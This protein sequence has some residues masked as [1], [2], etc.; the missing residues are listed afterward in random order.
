MPR[1]L[2]EIVVRCRE[3][4]GVFGWGREAIVGFLPFKHAK[5]FLNPDATEEEWGKF[6]DRLSHESV[7][8]EISKYMTFAWEKVEDHRGLSANRSIDKIGEWVWLL[9]SKYESLF[10]AFEDADYAQYGAPKLKVVCD[11]LGLPMP[12]S[13]SVRN[14]AEGHPCH[15]GCEEGC[16][17]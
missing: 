4:R 11:A 6:S 2:E 3:N 13:Q 8:A 14:M 1:S 17:Q 9:G 5:E 10:K 15:T 12:D 16:G 7:V